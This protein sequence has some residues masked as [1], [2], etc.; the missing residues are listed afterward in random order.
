MFFL[1]FIFWILW[2]TIS[3]YDFLFL[4][5][6]FQLDEYS[7]VR[8]LRFIFTKWGIGLRYF[9]IVAACLIAVGFLFSHSEVS[10]IISFFIALISMAFSYLIIRRNKQSEIKKLVLTGRIK[11]IIVLA[12]CWFLLESF[13]VMFFLINPLTFPALLAISN[14]KLILGMVVFL[15][16]GQFTQIS[17]VLV[18]I[19]LFPYEQIMRNYYVFSARKILDQLNPTVIGITGS[20]GKTSTKEILAHIISNYFDILKTPKSF[21]T[22]M[23]VCK[24]IREELNHTINFL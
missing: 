6:Y 22:L 11:R 1:L 23:G 7:G 2:V 15:L 16:I 24:V 10:V 8:F 5:K 13:F 19:F 4:V 3:I 17:I 21:N 9:E 14:D 18:N 12:I 20:Y